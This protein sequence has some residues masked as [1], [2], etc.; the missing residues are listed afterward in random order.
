M[1][2]S[3]RLKAVCLFVYFNNT[4]LVNNTRK[5]A[6]DF[7]QKQFNTQEAREKTHAAV[8]SG[9]N[10]NPLVRRFAFLFLPAFV[11]PCEYVCLS[12]STIRGGINID[13][14]TVKEVERSKRGRHLS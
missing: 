4:I 2:K 3:K 14:R 7:T 12:V 13:E 1:Y 10:G 9:E 6:I 11:H 8:Q 5:I